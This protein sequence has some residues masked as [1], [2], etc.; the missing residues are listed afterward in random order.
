[1]KIKHIGKD[2]RQWAIHRQDEPNMGS[3][4]WTKKFLFFFN[5]RRNWKLEGEKMNSALYK[6]SWFGLGL[7][8]TAGLDFIC[9]FL[10]FFFPLYPAIFVGGLGIQPCKNHS[11][12]GPS[13]L[14]PPFFSL[15]HWSLQHTGNF[16]SAHLFSWASFQMTSSKVCW[17]CFV[18]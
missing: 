5:V 12:K 17:L 13:S 7:E 9:G 1:M 18:C 6:P 16:I 3:E 11:S 2:M 15:S 14:R 10:L 4:N 8:P